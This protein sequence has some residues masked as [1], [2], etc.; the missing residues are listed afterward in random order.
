MMKRTLA[1]LALLLAA[2]QTAPQAAGPSFS[3]VLKPVRQ[4]DEVIAIDVATTITGAADKPFALIAPIVYPGSRDVVDRMTNLS[5]RDAQG[6]LPLTT[7]DDPAVPGGFPYFRHFA[8][9]RPAVWPVQLTYRALVQPAGAPNGP[10]FGIRPSGGGISGAGSTF[11]MIPEDMGSMPARVR[12]DLSGM[13]AG[14]FGVAS[15]GEGEQVVEAGPQQLWQSWFLAGPAPRYPAKGEASGFSAAWLGNFPFDAHAEMEWAGKLY[16]YLNTSF[17]YMDPAPHY[18]VFMRYL[19]TPPVGGGTALGNS[20]MLS[21]GVGRGG[22][23]SPRGTFAHEMIH[24]WVG[25]I[26]GPNGITS[27]FS[28]GLTTYYSAILPTRGGFRSV[29]EQARAIDG[30]ANGYWGAAA[31]NWSAARIAE[32]GFGD[33]QIRH[34]PYNRG[35]LYFADL[36]A[37]IRAKSGGRRQ[38]MDVLQPMFEGRE[39]GKPFTQDQWIAMVVAELGA[40]EEARF[41]SIILDGADLV[42]DAG[43][44]GPCFER[45]P[46]TY[47]VAGAQAAGYEWLRIQA[48]PEATCRAW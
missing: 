3:T 31:R 47:D 44:F 23:D 24:M 4:G 46:K 29:D 43:A 39:A 19:E 9:A 7:K 45:R 35:A 36:D 11:I 14:S 12:W 20:F 17:R 38:L 15:F 18:R 8:A 30:M 48:I 34:V 2:C 13:P 32:A 25:G 5:V 16:A 40:A 21:T 33:E 1:A 41:R 42:P 37:R 6:E 10:P 22:G 28:E 27:W 26:E